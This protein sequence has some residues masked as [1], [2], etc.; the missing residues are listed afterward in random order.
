MFIACLI[1][2]SASFT[3]GIMRSLWIMQFVT[4][5]I[6]FI[7]YVIIVV[8]FSGFPFKDD[9]WKQQAKRMLAVVC[10]WTIADF[11]EATM[12]NIWYVFVLHYCFKFLIL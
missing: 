11:A 5:V 3:N 12:L 10:V 4:P 8:K 7:F 6:A 1:T 2:A 9:A